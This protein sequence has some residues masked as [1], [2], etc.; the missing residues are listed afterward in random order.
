MN[1]HFPQKEET[2]DHLGS[3]RSVKKMDIEIW[4]GTAVQ[5]YI[6]ESDQWKEAHKQRDLCK[7]VAT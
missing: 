5:W 2:F 4:R 1:G 3:Y 6:I 7:T